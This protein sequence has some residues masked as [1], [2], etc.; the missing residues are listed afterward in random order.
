MIIRLIQHVKR[1]IFL[2]L[3]F[4]VYP[5]NSYSSSNTPVPAL[6]TSL[7]NKLNEQAGKFS[8]THPDSA[9]QI[10]DKAYSLSNE[11]NY[12]D[13]KL[14]ALRIKGISYYEKGF[15]TSSISF[16]EKIFQLASDSSS[17]SVAKAH[18][19][20]ALPFIAL[21][22]HD[23]ARRHLTIGLSIAENKN[24]ASLLGD[25]YNLIGNTYSYQKHY[26]KALI[27]YKKSQ[28]HY[29]KL[30]NR[31]MSTFI[32]GNMGNIYLSQKKYEM[33]QQLFQN[34]LDLARK[35]EDKNAMGNAWLCLADLAQHQQQNSKSKTYF[36]IAKVLLEEN[37]TTD[38][39]YVLQNLTKL[40]LTEGNIQKSMAYAQ[41]LYLRSKSQTTPNYLQ[42]A[43]LLLSKIYEKKHDLEKA[44]FFERESSK[45]KDTIQA[46]SLE[47]TNLLLK[48]KL[49][50]EEQQ[51]TTKQ[52]YSEKINQSNKFKA[53]TICIIVVLL[54][55]IFFLAF[56][57]YDKRKINISLSL[58]NKQIEIQNI[59]LM[60]ADH[61]KSNLLSIMAH[62]VRGPIANLQMLLDMIEQIDSNSRN[63]LLGSSRKEIERLDLFIR[64]L[65]EW[66]LLQ[67]NDKPLPKTRFDLKPLITETCG[68]FCTQIQ[69]K[70][71]KILNTIETSAFIYA[72]LNS[73]KMVL[74]NLIQNA[75][76]F[77]EPF[78]EINIS[79]S[80]QKN[81]QKATVTISDT[82][83]GISPVIQ[84]NLFKTYASIPGTQ[85][86]TGTGLGLILCKKYISLNDGELNFKSKVGLGSTFWFNLP[87]A[88]KLN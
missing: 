8:C 19:N 83:I 73:I 25:I 69:Q 3:L 35:Q 46:Q 61:F 24:Y 16:F 17:Y 71:L 33:A 62:D 60:E 75:I 14:A 18:C 42:E 54:L 4:C 84:K 10:A 48:Q 86:E 58:K 45:L 21:S 57:I 74:R 50:Y 80:Q 38:Y 79:F 63:E 81:L 11:L 32:L 68:L 56:Y 65:T 9:I 41:E 82:G 40:Y 49:K 28:E 26:E 51:N 6:D 47:D 13:G 5:Y 43:A 1:W 55:S 70:K 76:K 39:L 30:E 31:T 87:T 72:D 7:V 20:I 36:S 12:E 67:I 77:C 34:F 88:E 22:L 78:D 44:L 52:Q 64:D 85:N 23:K 53:Y 27:N 2:F 66:C 37:G 59:K 15:Y 29:V